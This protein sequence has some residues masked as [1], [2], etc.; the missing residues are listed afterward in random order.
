MLQSLV[1]LLLL[2]LFWFLLLVL[3]VVLLLQLLLPLHVMLVMFVFDFFFVIH[4]R[5]AASTDKYIHASGRSPQ[6]LRIC[7][8]AFV[9]AHAFTGQE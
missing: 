7:N 2:L 8:G 5:D 4:N 9:G 6:T 3:I 1:L